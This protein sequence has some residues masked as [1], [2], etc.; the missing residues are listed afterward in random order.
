VTLGTILNLK[1]H[2]VTMERKIIVT[3]FFFSGIGKYQ[4]SGNS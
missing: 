1:N 3:E 2:N 4:F